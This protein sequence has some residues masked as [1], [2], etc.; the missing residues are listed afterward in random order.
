MGNGGRMKSFAA[1]FLGLVGSV[2]IGRQAD[3]RAFEPGMDG[4]GG[5]VWQCSPPIGGR[6]HDIGPFGDRGLRAVESP[7]PIMI[8]LGISEAVLIAFP[9]R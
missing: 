7:D 6:V 2:S 4:R 9:A 3:E 8:L 5:N 1:F